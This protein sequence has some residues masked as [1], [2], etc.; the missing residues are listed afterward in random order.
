MWRRWRRRHSEPIH[1]CMAACVGG[2]LMA[3][4]AK[5]VTLVPWSVAI[6]VWLVFSVTLYFGLRRN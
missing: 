1:N 5:A 3:V 4:F 2:L 6:L